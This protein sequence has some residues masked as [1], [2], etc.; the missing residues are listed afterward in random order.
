MIELVKGKKHQ[1]IKRDNR[2]E[3][4]ND[5]KMYKVLLWAASGSEPLA[6][7][8]LNAIELKVFD[9][10]SISKLFDEVIET[11]ANLITDMFPIW[12]T[13]TR[14]LYLQKIYKEMWGMRRNEYPYYGEVLKKGVQYGVYDRKV[15]ESFTAQEIEELNSYIDPVKDTQL[16]YLGLRVFIDKQSKKYTATKVLELPQ[17]G[18]MRL[19][20]FAFWKE[21]KEVRL[22][23]IRERYEDLSDA[24]YSE[25]SPKWMNSLDYNPQ[26]ASCVVSKT[27]DNSWGIN[28]TVSNL[29]L[30]SKH[31]GGLATDISD[32]RA[33]GSKI[34]KA[35]KSSGP[36]PF[37]K[38]IESVVAAY[39]QNGCVSRNT[40]VKRIKEVKK[41]GIVYSIDDFITNFGDKEIRAYLEPTSANGGKGS[42]SATDYARYKQ[43]LTMKGRKDISPFSKDFY[44]KQGAT[45][46]EAGILAKD[47]YNKASLKA[48]ENGRTPIQGGNLTT[49]EAFITKYGQE[50]GIIKFNIYDRTRVKITSE[51]LQELY[52]FTSEEAAEFKNNCS[53]DKF[54]GRHGEE[55]GVIKYNSFLEKSVSSFRGFSKEANSFIEQVL[56][57]FLR[58]EH[59]MQGCQYSANGGEFQIITEESK[60]FKYDF[61]SED[62]G[63]IFEYHGTA[64]HPKENDTE[65][66]NPFGKTYESQFKLD[67]KKKETA[68]K[69]GYKYVAMYSDET[70]EYQSKIKEV[71]C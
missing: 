40:Y 60:L 7:E 68:E 15:I 13:V 37:V 3:E 54:I 67:S 33:T 39:N 62:L 21:P 12:D 47:A 31:G 49:I 65:W 16:D 61:I 8:L 38:L 20:L 52:G 17:H 69:L 57:P 11:S 9:K 5:E 4:Y 64:F 30:F 42:A 24:L 29:G 45:I 58:K 26:M 23:L 50:I 41:D 70:R 32:L 27:P 14:N 18:F 56:I 19:A 53:L 44:L 46:E 43:S 59:N 66:V 2:V 10:I 25:A 1:I 55:L 28:R 35:G 34:G 22:Q 71:L 6:K 51:Y 63:L 48:I 36:I